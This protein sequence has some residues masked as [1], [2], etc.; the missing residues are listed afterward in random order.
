[1]KLQDAAANLEERV[2]INVT[3]K[4]VTNQTIDA[5]CRH[6]CPE[7]HKG[8]FPSDMIPDNISSFSLFSIIVN[9]GTLKRKQ[10]IP[11]GHF[12]TIIKT[13]LHI[14][15]IDP[16]GLPCLQPDVIRFMML[17]QCPVYHNNKQIQDISSNYCGMFAILFSCYFDRKP[18]F[19]MT[20]S[21]QYKS[22]DHKC[23]TYLKKIINA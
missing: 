13:K 16:F 1:M 15:Y 22:N 17:C 8:T 4:G 10:L 7:I 21:A 6:L 11:I 5:F 20:F 18:S 14:I 12:V 9:L 3:S 19:S 23:I 2:K